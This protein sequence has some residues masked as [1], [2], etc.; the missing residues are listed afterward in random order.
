M[1]VLRQHDV[2]VTFLTTER[3]IRIHRDMNNDGATDAGEDVRVVELPETIG[4]GQAAAPNLASG[5]GPVTFAELDD[6]PTLVFHRNGS[7]SESGAAYLRPVEGSMSLDVEA[8]RGL[9]VERSTAQIRC[10]SYRTGS[11]ESAC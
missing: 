3:R 4:F 9:T 6:G 7:A 11:W 10:F 2:I 5:P 1:A 8:V